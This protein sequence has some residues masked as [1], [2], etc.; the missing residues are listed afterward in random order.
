MTSKK[1]LIIKAFSEMNIS[2]LEVTLDENKYYHNGLDKKSFIDKISDVFDR[3][4][5]ENDTILTPYKGNCKDCECFG[6]VKCTGFAFVGNVSNNGINMKF[7][8][9]ENDY[10]NIQRCHDFKIHNKSI[11]PISNLTIEEFDDLRI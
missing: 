8:E 5:K 9:I 7:E 3:F 2:L 4:K 6:K 1:E 11:K 10:F